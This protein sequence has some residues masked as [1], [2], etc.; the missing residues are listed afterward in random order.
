MKTN[1]F[2]A[3]LLLISFTSLRAQEYPPFPLIYSGTTILE[4]IEFHKNKDYDKAIANYELVSKNDT[5][6]SWALY[7]EA[8]SCMKNNDS[9]KAIE[10][11]KKGIALDDGQLILL[12]L[13]LGSAYDIADS[14]DKAI[15]TYNKGLQL[16]PY[17]S[18]FYF[19]MGVAYARHKNDSAAL[20]CFQKSIRMNPLHAGSHLQ[21]ADLAA[22]NNAYTQA[23]M[24][25][26]MFLLIENR[27]SRSVYALITAE[28]IGNGQYVSEVK[29]P[30]NLS[31]GGD[32]FSEIEEIIKSK[33]AIS[34]KYKTSVK[35]KYDNLIKP[36]QAMN[37]KLEYRASDKGFWMQTYVP[38]FTE[39]WKRGY[40]DA[41]VYDIFA[42][43]ESDDVQK[44]LKSNKS[45]IDK[46][47]DF[48]SDYIAKNMKRDNLIVNG[49]EYATASRSYDNGMIKSVGEFNNTTG[50]NL[51]PWAYFSYD[52]MV[53]SE[54]NYDS[55][56]MMDGEWKFYEKRTG[57]LA[58]KR[59]LKNDKLEG[60][61]ETYFLNGAVKEKGEYKNEK[62]NGL[63]IHYYNTSVVNAETEFL[64]GKKTGHQK[65]YAANGKLL[66][67]VNY[68]NGLYDGSYV[69]YFK[70]GKIKTETSFRADQQHGIQKT[71]FITGKLKSEGNYLN[72]QQDGEWKYYFENGQV[73]KSGAFKDGKYNGTWT[74][75]YENGQKES[76][77]IYSNGA[78]NG[79]YKLYDDDGIQ[80]AEF[81]YTAGRIKKYKYMDKSGKTVSSGEEKGG[82]LTLNS[83]YADGIMKNSEGTF[84]DGKRQGL[85]TQYFKC[86]KKANE[87]NYS[88]DERDGECRFYYVNGN[89]SERSEYTDGMMDGFSTTYFKNG[90][91]KSEGWYV[92]DE[93]QGTWN[94]YFFNKTLSR[95]AF[96][97]NGQ[98]Y[99]HQEY[100]DVKGRIQ[101]DNVYGEDEI[102]LEAN[103]YDTTGATLYT[104]RFVK[105]SGDYTSIHINGKQYQKSKWKNNEKD[106]E[107]IYYWPNGKKRSVEN[108]ADGYQMGLEQHFYPNGQLHLERYYSYDMNDSIERYYSETGK[109]KYTQAHRYNREEGPYV[110]YYDNGKKLNEGNY[111]NDEREGPF[112][113]Y[114]M[115]GTSVR[116]KLNYKE[117]VIISYSYLDAQG[118]Y[119][120]EIKV[121]NQSDKIVAY[122]QNGKKSV[123]IPIENGEYNGKRIYYHPNGN[124]ESEH[125][126][127]DDDLEGVVKEYYENGQL[128]SE[129]QYANGDNNGYAKYYSEKG[130]LTRE[131][132]YLCDQYYGPRIDYDETTG[133]VK[134][135]VFYVNNIPFE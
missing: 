2:I 122:Y 50:K 107:V 36:L 105:G 82:K 111:H 88:N 10:L 63:V 59:M 3:L 64:D 52:G 89:L 56:G 31:N 45:K 20:R 6:Y 117:G 91:V 11:C 130:V 14:L 133:K 65:V 106:G 43:L 84:I 21:I 124:V 127:K 32:D 108:H 96:Y 13:Q 73:S 80:Y 53:S 102:F 86:G 119:V 34:S 101:F 113:Y 72:G 19:E 100:Y 15:E 30:I 55:N 51:G 110:Y 37:E 35:L 26:Q 81:Q 83:Y 29:N 104:N 114:A 68:K 57:K 135:K 115:D 71:Y 49:K 74:E 109:L 33:T 22:R 134:K 40:F 77:T 120:P 4:G 125:P 8:L 131:E 62:V 121:N 97:M 12:Y 93:L 67:E 39:L 24:A 75:Y 16:F 27:S 41:V 112:I 28:K 60:P 46:M 54:G 25:F 23:L 70:N 85:W 99:G 61:Y 69:D 38:L 116:I 18:K 118:K 47:I 1:Y 98:V 129:R 95:K 92:D 42:S 123:E 103:G 90:N 44:A 94:Y 17:C 48:A 78:K 58:S 66:R 128:K 79:V 9:L 87:I 76:E 7:E 126:Y 132:T 5:N